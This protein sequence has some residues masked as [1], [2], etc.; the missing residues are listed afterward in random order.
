MPN[1][2]FRNTDE[3]ELQAYIAK[4]DMEE[5]VESLEF[6]QD[7]KWGGEVALT[8]G[9]TYYLEPLSERP[10]LPITLRLRRA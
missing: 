6:D 4:K 1:I 5:T 9:S 8:D 2:M 7:D 3:G 10:K